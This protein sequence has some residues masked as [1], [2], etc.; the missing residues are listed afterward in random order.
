[1]SRT[2]VIERLRRR[3]E[4]TLKAHL[5]LAGSRQARGVQDV[6]AAWLLQVRPGAAIPFDNWGSAVCTQ[7]GSVGVNGFVDALNETGA[8]MD[9]NRKAM[10]G[11]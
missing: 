6:P 1:M 3:L 8:M 4:M 11:R 5:Q 2:L 7:W 10:I 9:Q